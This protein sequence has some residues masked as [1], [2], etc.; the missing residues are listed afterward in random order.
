MPPIPHSF[1]SSTSRPSRSKTTPPRSAGELKTHSG[2]SAQPVV[3][4]GWLRCSLAASATNSAV[5]TASLTR[6]GP[7]AEH[8]LFAAQDAHRINLEADVLEPAPGPK[9][10]GG[11]CPKH[12]ALEMGEA[13]T[14]LG[15]E[16]TLDGVNI[17]AA[18]LAPFAT[19]CPSIGEP[20]NLTLAGSCNA[21]AHASLD[22]G[23]SSTQKVDFLSLVVP[24]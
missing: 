12:P 21:L 11:V 5:A 24:P 16:P 1:G 3:H 22:Q 19:A 13:V 23:R 7:S 2:C 20:G 6:L 14:L 18:D 8:A 10:T 4:T 9:R 15:S 17:N